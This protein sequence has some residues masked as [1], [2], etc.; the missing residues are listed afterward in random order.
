[1]KPL[2]SFYLS[3]SS[4][5]SIRADSKALE[6]SVLLGTEAHFGCGRLLDTV[7][8]R[9]N[10]NRALSGRLFG[11]LFGRLVHVR[12]WI[13]RPMFAPLLYYGKNR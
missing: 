13:F 5:T 1:M 9:R 7:T 6:R 10:R 4:T 12:T 11:Q 2:V 8:D 3:T